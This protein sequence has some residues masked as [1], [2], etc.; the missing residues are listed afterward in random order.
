MKVPKAQ[1]V[2]F[3]IDR[4]LNRYVPPSQLHRLP[5]PISRWLGYRKKPSPEVGNILVS[6]WAF[7]GTV[8]GLL[9][10]G[11]VLR[12]G[13]LVARYH[14]PIL[15]ASLVGGHLLREKLGLGFVANGLS[16]GAAAVLD[17]NTIQSPLAQPRNSVV[18]HTL[19]A[20]CG[21]AITKLFML[22]SN[23]EDLRWVA[24][25]VACGVASVVMG[26]TNS[27]HP[28]GGA[29]AVLAAIQPNVTDLGWLFPAFVLLTTALMVG[30]A[31]V[32][33]NIQRKFPSYWW[34]P[35]DVGRKKKPDIETASQAA[36]EKKEADKDFV[37]TISRS[38][39][40]DVF[41]SIVITTEHVTLPDGFTLGPEEVGVVEILRNR[42]R[43]M[44]NE[45]DGEPLDVQAS[46]SSSCTR[47][48][49]P[50][51]G[52]AEDLG[53]KPSSVLG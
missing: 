23:F 45:S 16:Q 42:L 10:V 46:N 40:I 12:Y 32:I 28:P 39:P 38:D 15:I 3:D 43:E 21:V 48:P 27:Q 33:N 50:E 17:Y 26:M 4:Y 14:P 19:A 25:A 5:A 35:Q 24:G 6:F 51:R 20:L 47:I 22:S 36:S 41:R 1:D 34:T 30:V 2:H 44:V 29:T 8:A 53:T 9:V 18:G 7:V 37:K 52:S 13:P 49:S 11:A 31:L